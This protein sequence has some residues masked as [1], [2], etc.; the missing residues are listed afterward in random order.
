VEERGFREGKEG[1]RPV[2]IVY[3]IEAP[4]HS[5]S[6][7][8]SRLDWAEGG[9]YVERMKGGRLKKKAGRREQDVHIKKEHSRSKKK[10][11]RQ[12]L[13]RKESKRQ[14]TTL[15]LGGGN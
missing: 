3:S 12:T 14:K 6:G 5:R 10:G 11:S 13:K 7:K 4:R 9:N 1:R 8:R 2:P 15:G